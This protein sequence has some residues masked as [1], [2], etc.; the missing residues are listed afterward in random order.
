MTLTRR[1]RVAVQVAAWLFLVLI[2]APAVLGVVL[3]AWL[4]VPREAGQAIGVLGSITL[5][6]ATSIGGRS[7]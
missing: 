6:V 2:V 3:F 1:G 4:V 7:V 5:M